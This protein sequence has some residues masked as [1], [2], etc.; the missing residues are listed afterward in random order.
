MYFCIPLVRTP[1]ILPVNI[2]FKNKAT[3]SVVKTYQG[4]NI[5]FERR[6]VVKN[7]IFNELWNSI[8]SDRKDVNLKG[9][10]KWVG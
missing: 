4:V 5:K 9:A 6:F 3:D 1:C 2:P 10:I 8:A 7:V